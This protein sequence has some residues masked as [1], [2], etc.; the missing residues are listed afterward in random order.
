MIGPR[1]ALKVLTNSMPSPF[2]FQNLRWPSALAVKKNSDRGAAAVWVT[3]SRCMKLRSYMAALGSASRKAASCG[4]TCAHA[5]QGCCVH[6]ILCSAVMRCQ[7]DV[8]I[9][10]TTAGGMC[11]LHR[12]YPPSLGLWRHGTNI[13]AL[14]LFS[15]Q[16]WAHKLR[17]LRSVS[18]R[19]GC[20][21][22]HS[23]SLLCPTLGVQLAEILQ[24]CSELSCSFKMYSRPCR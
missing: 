22:H 12:T 18:L 17:S 5:D 10:A 11:A 4:M 9:Q 23:W 19:L 6:S 8:Y 20:L 2:F 15:T 16:H 14:L 1:C 24:A 7:L 13:W 21:F 3:V